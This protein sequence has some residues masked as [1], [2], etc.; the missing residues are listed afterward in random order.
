MVHKCT[1]DRGHFLNLSKKSLLIVS[2]VE[3]SFMATYIIEP[4]SSGPAER[5]AE[6]LQDLGHRL[7]FIR[8]NEGDAI[9]ADASDI[10]A[11]V[12]MG[13][14][15]SAGSDEGWIASAKELVRTLDAAAMPVLGICLGAQ[16]VAHALGGEV[17]SVEAG[18]QF[19]LADIALTPAGRDDPLFAGLGWTHVQMHHHGEAIT[20]LPDGA[21]SLAKSGDTAVQAFAK[22]LRTYGFQFHPECTRQRLTSWCSTEASFMD[23]AGLTLD[24]FERQLAQ[25]NGGFADYERNSSR[26]LERVALLLMP[27]DRRFAG[28]SGDLRH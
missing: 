7:V 22:G 3:C 25:A 2:A 10:D 16:I 26:L 5:L 9:P 14:A 11:L 28:T 1:Q 21:K 4:S 15:G 23:Q 18:Y 27:V 6:V 12:I 13:G 20:T 19:G 24:A 17:G 8:P